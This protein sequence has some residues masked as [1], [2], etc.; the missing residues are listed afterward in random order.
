[1]REVRKP[2]VVLTPKQ[3][4]RMKET[5]SAVGELAD[6]W[7]RETLDDAT[8]TDR[9]AITRVVLCSGKVVWDLL[10]ERN[11]LG[12]P[13]AV[14]RVEQLYPWPEAQIEEILAGYPNVT[15]VVWAQEE[16]LNM[17]PW[18]F[19]FHQ[20]HQVSNRYAL[21]VAA[22]VA[23][24]SPATGSATIHKEELQDL[25]AEAVATA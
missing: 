16:P 22:R 2:L 20:L 19:V 24:G 18:P 12:T 6:G 9:N 3:P 15:E 11:R 17:G 8:V 5:R 25:L 13:V 1:V 23:S 14:V 10:A 7:F 4:L 21:R